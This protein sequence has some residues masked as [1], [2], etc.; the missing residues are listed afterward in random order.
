MITRK[1]IRNA[2]VEMTYNGPIT[3]EG[4]GTPRMATIQRK[5]RSDGGTSN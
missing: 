5:K 1:D 4:A 2:V 3:M